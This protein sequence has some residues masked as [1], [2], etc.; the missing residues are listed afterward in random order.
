MDTS[1][2]HVE[3]LA[4]NWTAME[5]LHAHRFSLGMTIELAYHSGTAY[6][7]QT[8]CGKSY[9]KVYLNRVEEETVLLKRTM[10]RF[11]TIFDRAQ[12]AIIEAVDTYQHELCLICNNS[13]ILDTKSNIDHHKIYMT[14]M[15]CLILW[16]DYIEPFI[17]ALSESHSKLRQLLNEYEVKNPFAYEQK[18]DENEKTF[19]EDVYH[20]LQFCLAVINANRH[21]SQLRFP[22]A[23]LHHLSKRND[24]RIPNQRAMVRWLTKVEGRKEYVPDLLACILP[25][26]TLEIV[27]EWGAILAGESS[28]MTPTMFFDALCGIVYLTEDKSQDNNN[29]TQRLSRLIKN[30]IQMGSQFLQGPDFDFKRLRLRFKEKFGKEVELA[31]N[32]RCCA[33]ETKRGSFIIA[34]DNPAYRLIYSDEQ[35]IHKLTPP[36]I[37]NTQFDFNSGLI[38]LPKLVVLESQKNLLVKELPKYVRRCKELDITPCSVAHGDIGFLEEGKGKE[39]EKDDLS[40]QGRLFA[41][42]PQIRQ[43]FCPDDFETG[44][45]TVAAKFCLTSDQIKDIFNKTELRTDDEKLRIYRGV[46]QLLSEY[47][48]TDRIPQTTSGKEGQIVKVAQKAIVTHQLSIEYLGMFHSLINDN[49]L[50]DEVRRKIIRT[51]GNELLHNSP[52]LNYIQNESPIKLNARWSKELDDWQN[53]YDKVIVSK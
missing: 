45:L 49:I 21:T 35:S 24:P 37:N 36:P 30:L 50:K 51:L 20:D 52:L 15:E 10:R 29:N 31:G 23:E 44:I 28:T 9:K 26:R 17:R 33:M 53:K 40:A 6:D 12:K 7:A 22:L 2:S 4:Y 41:Q 38:E 34:P 18:A 43:K 3:D 8:R 27:N 32:S 1:L 25:R 42:G 47:I 5:L 46:G 16:N 19:N 11:D 39:K 13:K 48:E 14:A